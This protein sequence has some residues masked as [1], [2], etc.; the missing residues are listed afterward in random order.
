[1]KKLSVIAVAGLLVVALVQPATAGGAG[2]QHVEGAISLPAPFVQGTFA[3]CWG[4]ATRRTYTASQNQVNGVVGFAFDVDKATWNK[5]FVLEA[6]GGQ[7]TV[8][9]DLFM[10]STFPGPE[11]TPNDP[12]NGGTPVSVDFQT[13]AAGGESG[14]VPV[15]TVKAI[16]C[17]YAG[18]EYAG[19]DSTFS[20]MAGK[21]VKL[22]K[23]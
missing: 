12:V 5:P 6:A 18:P 22:P 8:D 11:E 2:H 10:Y 16:V 9:L 14:K 3:G 23:S 17:M 1:M 15:G 4:G 19:V 13:R 21:G 7:G 20:Y